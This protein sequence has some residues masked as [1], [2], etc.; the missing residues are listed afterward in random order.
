[1]KFNK[2]KYQVLHFDHNDS[3]AGKLCREK[4]SGGVGQRSAENKPA[5]CPAV[6]EGQ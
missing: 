1:M 5:A 3:M 4:G 6:Q 2:T